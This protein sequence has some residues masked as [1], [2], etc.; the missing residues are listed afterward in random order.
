MD[1]LNKPISSFKFDDIVSFCK[2]GHCEGVELDYKSDLSGK[3]LAKHFAAFSNA[4]GGVI[5]I[6]VDEDKKTASPKK[7]EGVKNAGKLE[8]RIHQS[9]S[10]VKP[11]PRYEVHTT[12]EKNGKVFILIR[13]LEGDRTPY[14]VQND[15]NLW[16]RTGNITS[17]IDQANPNETELLVLKK[18]DAQKLRRI[19]LLR[20]E[21][22]FK[23][24]IQRAE[25]DRVRLAAE[26]KEQFKKEQL[27]KSA[28]QGLAGAIVD[29]FKPKIYQIPIGSRTVICKIVIQPYYPR[30]F[31]IT[32]A[33]I[34]ES[35]DKFAFKNY[36]SRDFPILN[37]KPIPCG[38]LGVEWSQYS[39]DIECQQ[40]YSNGLVFDAIDIL[41]SDEKGRRVWISHIASKLYILLKA[42]KNFYNLVGYQGGI[43]GKLVIDGLDSKIDVYKI[44][45]S[46]YNR[47][48]DEKLNPL[49][50]NYKWGLDLDTS[51]LNNSLE[52]QNFFIDKIKEIYWHLGAGADSDDLYKVYLKDQRWLVE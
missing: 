21:E 16:I 38:V 39:G 22:V 5:I 28:E 8:E 3:G 26:E 43:V 49:L 48:F 51:L 31:L 46:H 15:P 14:Y 42:A 2:E 12:N 41:K 44:T 40:V 36:Y 9:A 18:R 47:F 7:W 30:N 27:K 45:P 1:L 13:I 34:K 50:P 23:A 17:L 20:A 10:N 11:F 35:V 33:G 52:F 25:E 32:P 6:G 19:N 4:R 24:A 37:V 29:Q